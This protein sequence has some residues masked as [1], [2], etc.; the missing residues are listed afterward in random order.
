MKKAKRI[1]MGKNE[2]ITKKLKKYI[3]NTVE[4]FLFGKNKSA[5]TV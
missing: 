5:M 2:K 1:T 4:L 3:K